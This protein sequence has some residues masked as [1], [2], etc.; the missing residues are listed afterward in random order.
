MTPGVSDVSVMVVA[1]K[2]DPLSVSVYVPSGLHVTA[3]FESLR[4]PSITGGG[5]WPQPPGLMHRLS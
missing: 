3:T 1:V 5:V 4:Q 2:L